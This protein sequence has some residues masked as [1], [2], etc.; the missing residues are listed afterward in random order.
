MNTVYF[1]LGSNIGNSEEQLRLATIIIEKQ[2][3]KIIA[4]SAIYQTAAWG[5]TDQP[6]FL[7]QVIIVETILWAEESLSAILTIEEKMGRVRTE[8]NAPRI[9]DIDILFFNDAIIQEKELTVPHPEIQNRLFALIPLNELSPNYIHPL[10]N[11]TVHELL[12][13]CKDVLNVKKF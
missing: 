2:I 1:L 9:I 4:R 3:G 12:A 6:D 10:L 5:K 11:K 13:D 8:K 7:N